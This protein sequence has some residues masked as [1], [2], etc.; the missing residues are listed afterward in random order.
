MLFV[1]NIPPILFLNLVLLHTHKFFIFVDS[2]NLMFYPY[3][4]IMCPMLYHLFM[5][6]N[7]SFKFLVPNK[8]WLCN[9]NDICKNWGI[10]HLWSFKLLLPAIEA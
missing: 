9:G 7:Q 3:A 2:I 4:Y 5:H 6:L 1:E 10:H 8:F